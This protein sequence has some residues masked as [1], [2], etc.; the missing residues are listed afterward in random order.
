MRSISPSRKSARHED[1]I[2]ELMTESDPLEKAVKAA[3]AALAAEKKQVEAEK[4]KA[5]ERTAVD[6]KEIDG[7]LQERKL[8]LER[9]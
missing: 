2:L 7:L 6:Q 8:I 3:E 4:S 9:R 5:R 1:R